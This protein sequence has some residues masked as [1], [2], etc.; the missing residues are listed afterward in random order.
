MFPGKSAKQTIYFDASFIKIG[1]EIRKLQWFEY[2][3]N[4]RHGCH[5]ILGFVMSYS[6]HKIYRNLIIM[7]LQEYF[8]TVFNMCLIIVTENHFPQSN[9]NL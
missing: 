9:S 8:D 4:G 7:G 3:Q 6:T 2:F 5:H 1:Q